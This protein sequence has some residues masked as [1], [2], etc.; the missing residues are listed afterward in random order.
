[1]KKKAKKKSS[2]KDTKVFEARLN[3]RVE[4]RFSVWKQNNSYALRS[5]EEKAEI[6]RKALDVEVSERVRLQ[7][8]L[9]TLLS[10][11]GAFIQ[12]APTISEKSAW[13]WE[14]VLQACNTATKDT[15]QQELDKLK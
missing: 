12:C 10:A 15:I 9:N 5:C 1:M 7:F 4:E 6:T 3:K 11:V 14:K 8:K 13:A 2:V